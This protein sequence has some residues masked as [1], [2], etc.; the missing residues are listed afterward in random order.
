MEL[1][2]T[3]SKY[4]KNKV[5]EK[6]Q[7]IESSNTKITTAVNKLIK[8][9]IKKINEVIYLDEEIEIN[10]TN[11]NF[12]PERDFKNIYDIIF[13]VLKYFPNKLFTLSKFKF[14]KVRKY[15][16]YKINLKKTKEYDTNTEYLLIGYNEYDEDNSIWVYGL[17]SLKDL[18]ENIKEHFTM[19]NPKTDIRHEISM[20]NSERSS[21]FDSKSSKSSSKSS[22][23][24]SGKSSSK[25]SSKSSG[26]SSGKSSSKSSGKSSS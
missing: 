6:Y 3:L 17:D 18:N 21:R 22:G 10:Y 24:S 13:I 23:K 25:S 5:I 26:K 16:V 8:I 2:T 4:I 12:I 14:S 15:F 9:L 20:N 11:K 1:N 7:D 19:I